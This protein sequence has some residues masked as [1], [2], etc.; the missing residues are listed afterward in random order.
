[1]IQPLFYVL[2]ILKKYICNT[3]KFT[4][5]RL[6]QPLNNSIDDDSILS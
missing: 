4:L 6:A 2:L 3:F 1:M 5:I